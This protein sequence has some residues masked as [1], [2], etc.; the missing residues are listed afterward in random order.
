[1]IGK[2]WV[3]N[4]FVLFVVSIFYGNIY[5]LYYFESIAIAI[6]DSFSTSQFSPSQFFQQRQFVFITIT[7]LRIWNHRI[8]EIPKK[9][10]LQY[11]LIICFCLLVMVGESW[12]NTSIII[13]LKISDQMMLTSFPGRIN[14]SSWWQIPCGHLFSL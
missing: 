6:S 7:Y 3:K 2:Y 9:T 5:T 12:T 1:M 13:V 8:H 14:I 4:V 11:S 10:V